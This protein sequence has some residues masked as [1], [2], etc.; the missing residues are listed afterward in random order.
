MIYNKMNATVTGT[1]CDGEDFTE[2]LQFKM[3][4]PNENESYYGTG[5]YMIVKMSLSGERYCDVRYECTTDIEILADRFIKNWYGN[6]A[7]EIIKRF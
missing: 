6:N 1:T 2:E 4:P 7:K 5:Y 3:I